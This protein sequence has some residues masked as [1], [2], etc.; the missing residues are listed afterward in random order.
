M[1]DP[2]ELFRLDPVRW[3]GASDVYRRLVE[4]GFTEEEALGAA[5]EV[6]SV[7]SDAWVDLGTHLPQARLEALAGR[8]RARFA[9]QPPEAWEAIEA[10]VPA[11]ERE[12][13]RILGGEG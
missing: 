13:L 11:E 9:G 12:A 8:Y 10:A 5:R 2:E 3:T 1:T 4:E 7:H 6:P